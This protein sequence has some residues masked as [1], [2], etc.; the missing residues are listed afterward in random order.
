MDCTHCGAQLKDHAKFCHVCGGAVKRPAIKDEH[1]ENRIGDTRI[2]PEIAPLPDEKDGDDKRSRKRKRKKKS[3]DEDRTSVTPALQPRPSAVEAKPPKQRWRDLSPKERSRRVKRIVTPIALLASLA[4]LAFAGYFIYSY[5]S[6]AGKLQLV[7]ENFP[8]PAFRSALAEFDLDGDQALDESEI[9]RVTALSVP[10]SSIVDTKG[11]SHF[12]NIEELD[13][14]GNEIA[15]IGLNALPKLRM[16]DLSSNS[17]KQLDVSG[18]SALERLDVSDN[19]LTEIGFG[20]HP[21]LTTLDVSGNSLKSIDTSEMPLLATLDVSDNDLTALDIS[22]NRALASLTATENDIAELDFT[23]HPELRHIVYDPDTD[24]VIALIDYFFP[25]DGLREALAT[26]DADGN[27]RLSSAERAGITTL[28]LTDY[29]ITDL[30]GLTF[31]PSLENLTL[32]GNS[33]E[34]FE[35]TAFPALKELSARGAGLTSVDVTGSPE[36]I[37]LDVK[38]NA[39]SGLDLSTQTK[40]V[41]LNVIGTGLSSI[42]LDDL[43][44]SLTSLYVDPSMEVSGVVAKTE[45]MFPSAAFRDLVFG[46]GA[47]ANEDHLLTPQEISSITNLDVSGKGLVSIAGVGYLSAI[48]TLDCSGNDLTQLRLRSNPSLQTLNCSDNDIASLDISGATGLRELDVS[49]NELTALDISKNPELRMLRATGNDISVIS[50]AN[51]PHL[52]PFGFNMFMDFGV[53]PL[54]GD[55]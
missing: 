53:R 38:D 41:H 52:S 1:A 2:L 31:F 37:S 30:T 4:A 34:T 27:G 29:G 14:N 26:T 28:D 25:D 7:E 23:V 35:S 47:N 33:I 3:E 55:D 43:S 22:Q 48:T 8:D 32:D 19:D 15:S 45:G 5:L 21:V 18:L 49:D 24:V 13:L 50:I 10:E 51:N 16:V 42:A 12:F 6:Q 20:T 9:A 44:G 39:L 40:L 11:L 17:L 54:W 46:L 36:L